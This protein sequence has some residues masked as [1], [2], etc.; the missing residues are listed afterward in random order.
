MDDEPTHAEVQQG[1]QAFVER[2]VRITTRLVRFTPQ[3]E[4]AGIASGFIL[5]SQGRD[6]L[7]SAGHAF[8]S[9]TQ[10]FLEANHRMYSKKEEPSEEALLIRLGPAQLVSTIALTDLEKLLADEASAAQPATF[11]LPDLKG[12]CP[13][14]KASMPLDIAWV[15]LDVEAIVTRAKA[16]GS[17]LDL[18]VY[19]GPLDSETASTEPYGFASMS[20][21]VVEPHPLHNKRILAREEA[22]ELC[23]EFEGVDQK[24]DLYRFKL[25]RKHMGHKYYHGASGSPIADPSGAIV[26]TVVC[27]SETDDIIYGFP[28]KRIAHLL[29]LG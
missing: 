19:V 18:E 27:G 25:A 3:G 12:A 13:E 11:Q 7:I 1:A 10:W 24:Y 17:T 15:E 5:R 26:A 6:F 14:S 8:W 4:I 22:C 21:V 2:M 23:M 16:A 9:G 29:H 28:L 20:R